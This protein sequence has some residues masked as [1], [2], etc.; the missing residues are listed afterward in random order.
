M[1]A[2]ERPGDG[3]GTDDPGPRSQAESVEELTSRSDTRR[4]TRSRSTGAFLGLPIGLIPF[5]ELCQRRPDRRQDSVWAV[6]AAA[7]G[8]FPFRKS[9]PT[10]SDQTPRVVPI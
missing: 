4:V 9:F 1:A 10:A 8:P 5:V 3:E 6:A 7:P 2:E